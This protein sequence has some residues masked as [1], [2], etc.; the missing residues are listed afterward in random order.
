MEHSVFNQ[1]D[2]PHYY[3]DVVRVL[4]LIAALI[5]LLGLPVFVDFLNLP[6]LYS[7]FAIVILGLS[8]GLTNPKQLWIAVVNVVISIYGFIEFDVH[9][10]NA[11][12]TGVG[13]MKFFISNLV[14]SFIFLMAIYFSVKTL[15]GRL[16]KEK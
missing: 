9:S 6:V 15:R 2:F 4:F 10:V 3:G 16:V 5:M 11:S 12:R 7:I 13:G 1:S 8:A 14:L